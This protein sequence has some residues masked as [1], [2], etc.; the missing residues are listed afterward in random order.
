[1]VF[2]EIRAPGKVFVQAERTMRFVSGKVRE[3]LVASPEDTI[4]SRRST[5][6]SLES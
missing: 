5:Y 6:F 4:D 1:M 3:L 2:S